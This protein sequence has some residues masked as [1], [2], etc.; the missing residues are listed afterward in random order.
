MLNEVAAVEAEM[1][2]E[3]LAVEAETLS[4]LEALIETALAEVDVDVLIDV[5]VE[6]TTLVEAAAEV[7]IDADSSLAEVEL[8]MEADCS[9]ST[10]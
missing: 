8:L 4:E 6:S 1:L 5:L 2:N 9:G 7:L 10:G 3:V